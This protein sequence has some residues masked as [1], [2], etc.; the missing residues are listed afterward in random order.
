[1]PP[2]FDGVCMLK[3]WSVSWLLLPR[4]SNCNAAELTDNFLRLFDRADAGGGSCC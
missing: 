2:P 1:M 4:I 3:N